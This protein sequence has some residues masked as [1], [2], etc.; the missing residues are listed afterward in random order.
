MHLSP[1]LTTPDV[2][3]ISSSSTEAG[4]PAFTP[5]PFSLLI[6]LLPLLRLPF[7]SYIS[8]ITRIA[9]RA[10]PNVLPLLGT[11]SAA[12]KVTTLGHTGALAGSYIGEREM[13]LGVVKNGGKALPKTMESFGRLEGSIRSTQ[14]P[15]GDTLVD[16]TS[17]PEPAP[18]ARVKLK[19]QCP[20]VRASS[21]L[22][23]ANPD[24]IPPAP[25]TVPSNFH[26]SVTSNPVRNVSTPG[27]PPA[28]GSKAA[29]FDVKATKADK[30]AP[31]AEK[32]ASRG[33]KVVTNVGASNHFG[34]PSSGKR[35]LWE[36]AQNSG[37]ADR[38]TIFAETESIWNSVVAESRHTDP[39]DA[40]RKAS[41]GSERV[42]TAG[43]PERFGN[44][45]LPHN[46]ERGPQQITQEASAADLVNIFKT[47]EDFG[48]SD[49]AKS[50]TTDPDDG[51]LELI[52]LA[53]AMD[54]LS[55]IQSSVA[56]SPTD[57]QLLQS[58][59]S[60]PHPL[61]T[62]L[63][64][65]L[66]SKISPS[67][68]SLSLL[69]L[70]CL[71]SG[72]LDDA[73]LIAD[74]VL[75]EA[76]F[77][78]VIS[79]SEE[80]AGE[81][82]MHPSGDPTSSSQRVLSPDLM[83]ILPES[84]SSSPSQSDVLVALTVLSIA[85]EGRGYHYGSVARM[86]QALVQSY[87]IP[88]TSRDPFTQFSFHFLCSSCDALFKSFENADL[89][90]E[91]WLANVRL[92]IASLLR[93]VQGEVPPVLEGA[94][95]RVAQNNFED[96]T[97]STVVMSRVAGLGDAK[98][99]VAHVLEKLVRPESLSKAIEQMTKYYCG[100]IFN[101]SEAQRHLAWWSEHSTISATLLVPAWM[102]VMRSWTSRGEYRLA[103]RCWRRV[104]DS[105]AVINQTFAVAALK[106]LSQADRDACLD[107]LQDMSKKGW[108]TNDGLTS[109]AS[110][111][112]KSLG[113][114]GVLIL[115]G[116]MEQAGLSWSSTILAAVVSGLAARVEIE[117]LWWAVGRAVDAGGI[118]KETIEHD[119]AFRTGLAAGLRKS[120]NPRKALQ[121]ISKVID[122]P[123]NRI[124]VNEEW[125]ATGYLDSDLAS[126]PA[127]QLKKS[128]P[129]HVACCALLD[130]GQPEMAFSLASYSMTHCKPTAYLVGVLALTWIARGDYA[131]AIS[132]VQKAMST[133]HADAYVVKQMMLWASE[134]EP[135]PDVMAC[136][137]GMKWLLLNGL[138][139]E[140][141]PAAFHFL[142]RC[143]ARVGDI[144]G[145]KDVAEQMIHAGFGP[146]QIS[147]HNIMLAC[148][149]RARRAKFEDQQ[150]EAK[151]EG[152]MWFEE[153]KRLANEDLDGTFV[154]RPSQSREMGVFDSWT[155]GRSL[156]EFEVRKRT[157]LYDYLGGQSDKIQDDVE[158][159]ECSE[160]DGS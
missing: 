89:E 13:S 35:G 77:A 32:K 52:S 65:E 53:V 119:V 34:F 19:R 64:T 116:F 149:Q 55:I 117:T 73:L 126:H 5:S 23:P 58:T 151:E 47:T 95:A 12:Q 66:A 72:R 49:V 159:S 118:D 150:K 106:P 80:R 108:I 43:A 33:G 102:E 16:S 109:A 17:G 128:H 84:V 38:D 90:G 69:A 86:R 111:L 81:G 137:A 40:E 133:P 29:K 107:H 76:R 105:G 156:E 123:E 147:I 158:A 160:A 125:V 42:P 61:F 131:T 36:F 99:P 4:R 134:M 14:I 18:A 120:G 44:V 37:P 7:S 127:G 63:L 28:R 139:S 143:K 145:T 138:D 20:T 148:I 136:E 24:P 87:T 141:D 15:T 10:S 100:D 71:A 132:I 82:E 27:A 122:F 154:V 74:R 110:G 26:S 67:S 124:K 31:K 91:K 51:F 113:K 104:K 45:G 144:Q 62:A 157:T 155:L 85:L 1:A 153:L 121:V 112:V 114:Q 98:R 11:V 70:S 135:R 25:S 103:S 97:F 140:G 39:A 54:P 68:T 101:P 130:L 146:D 142:M 94:V 8:L 75:K 22:S 59:I 9:R 41:Y 92:F 30:K 46:V 96:S 129:Y 50:R 83:A 115:E 93:I 57:S 78:N 56:P 6:G 152:L 2:T 3:S 79:E 48:N 21:T 88:M 60:Q